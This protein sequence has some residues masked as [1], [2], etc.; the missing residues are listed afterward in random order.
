MRIS[1]EQSALSVETIFSFFAVRV[2]IVALGGNREHRRDTYDT[3]GLGDVRDPEA[4][5]KTSSM[6]ITVRER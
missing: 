5:R 4:E 3:F 2:S 1:A 6:T